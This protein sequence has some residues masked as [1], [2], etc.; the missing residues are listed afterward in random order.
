MEISFLN[1]GAMDTSGGNFV[2]I[3]TYV[4]ERERERANSTFQRQMIPVEELYYDI[5]ISQE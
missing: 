3:S 4:R 2:Q 5:S 1:E